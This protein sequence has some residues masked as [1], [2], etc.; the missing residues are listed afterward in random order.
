MLVAMALAF[1][2]LHALALEPASSDADLSIAAGF[3][4]AALVVLAHVGVGGAIYRRWRRGRT[5]ASSEAP[6]SRSP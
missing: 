2:A 1:L 3:G 4:L 5:G 6:P